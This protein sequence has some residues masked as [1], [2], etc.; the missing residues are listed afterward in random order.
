MN[1][2]RSIAKTIACIV[3]SAYVGFMIAISHV[4]MKGT[5]LAIARDA[6]AVQM[7]KCN[8]ALPTIKYCEY[9]VIAYVVGSTPNK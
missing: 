1:N 7:D 3:V 2:Y 5:H 6:I 4:P 8:A 9:K